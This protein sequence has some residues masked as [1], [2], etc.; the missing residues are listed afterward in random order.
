LSPNR[1]WEFNVRQNGADISSEAFGY[2]EAYYAPPTEALEKIEVIRGAAALQY[3]PQFGGLLNYV[4]KKYTGNKVISIESQQTFGSYGLFNSYNAVGGRIKKFTYYAYLHHRNADGWRENSRYQINTGSLSM[5]YE[6]SKKW[7]V[8]LEY[9]RMNYLSQQAGGLTD[10]MYQ[11][12]AR[13]SERERNWFSTPWNTAS[14]NL[15]YN[16]SHQTRFVLKAFGTFAERNS[17]GFTKAITVADTFNTTLGSFNPRQVDRD[18]YTNIGTELRGIHEYN[19]F[20]NRSAISSGIRFYSGKTL[21]MQ[22]GIGSTGSEYEL[23]ISTQHNGYD[24]AKQLAFNTVNAAAFIE[25]MFSI[26]SKFSVTPGIRYELIQSAASGRINTS[27]TG[28]INEEQKDRNIILLG[29]STEYTVTKSSN[30]Y[31][32]FSQGYRPVTYSEMSPSATTD[33]IDPNLKDASGYNVDLGYRGTILK[34]FLK[35]D[36]SGFRLLYDNRIGTITKDGKPFKTNIGTSVSQGLESFIEINPLTLLYPNNRI[37]LSL[38]CNYSF[39]DARY[40]RWDNPDLLSDPE[41][42]IKDKRVEN[43][44]KNILRSGITFRLKGFS[45][46]LQYNFVDEVYTD[47]ANTEEANSTFTTGKLDA[48]KLLDLNMSYNVMDT[49]IFKAGI[50]NLTDTKYATRRAGGYPGPGLLPGTGRTFYLTVGIKL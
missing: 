50:N 13:Q 45:T 47:A 5:N 19:L 7:N 34:N 30:I 24:Y 32:N 18:E 16:L 3:G 1:S 39:I 41:K 17:V 2:P 23:M 37:N 12:D 4:T 22:Q 21:R 14:I 9:T 42:T 29:F 8:S 11:V 43:A 33:V 28:E 20:G 26:T 49:Y 31:A 25:N 48:Y 10:S 15:N 6:I 27:G 44:P 46:T 36:I 40:T 38:F 35:F